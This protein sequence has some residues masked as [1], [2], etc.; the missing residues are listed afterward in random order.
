MP[1]FVDLSFTEVVF[2]I[3]DQQCLV[4]LRVEASEGLSQYLNIVTT[5][6]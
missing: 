4:M 2:W 6:D 3:K 1:E 5:L